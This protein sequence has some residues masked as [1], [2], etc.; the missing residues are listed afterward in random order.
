M[1]QEKNRMRQGRV[2]T[3]INTNN[4]TLSRYRHPHTCLNGK[5]GSAASQE[6]WH[7]RK[8]EDQDHPQ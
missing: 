2:K 8:R 6:Q 3:Q 5:N 1:D 7:R 4:L